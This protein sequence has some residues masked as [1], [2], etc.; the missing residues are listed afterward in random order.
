MCLVRLP[1]SLL[2]FAEARQFVR[3]ASIYV[4][5]LLPASA[6]R[7]DKPLCPLHIAYRSRDCWVSTPIGCPDQRT[8]DDTLDSR[9]LLSLRSWDVFRSK[10]ACAASHR[11]AAV[12]EDAT[13]TSTA[14]PRPGT[15]AVV[16][17]ISTAWMMFPYVLEVL[18][19]RA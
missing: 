17:N 18:D 11:A 1:A 7:F 4:G 8:I 19:L 2:P 5:G 15:A 13:Q 3:H 10:A 12:V 9:V 16:K 6:A 14:S